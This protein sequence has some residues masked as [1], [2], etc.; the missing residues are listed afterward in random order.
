[1]I[2]LGLTGSIGMGKTTAARQLGSFGIPV[3][4]ADA[5]VHQLLGEGGAAVEPIGR[6][7]PETLVDRSIDRH[8][9]GAR[10][11]G[12]D[13]ALSR[14]EAVLHPLVRRQER[15]FIERSRR[16]RK[17]IVV[18]DVPLL[19]ETGA[20]GRVDAVFVVSCPAFLQAQR[21]LRR[22]GMTL[23]KLTAIRKRQM[24]DWQKR[25]LADSI[26]PTGAGRRLALRTLCAAV[27]HLLKPDRT[28]RRGRAEPIE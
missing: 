18:L 7:F 5:V 4:D 1:M 27:R 28:G 25:R 22:P 9:L 12:D 11:F 3:Y 15:L 8:L 26:I 21:V 2:V 10:V 19:Y 13:R 24:P 17:R 6:I 23:E 14:L 20:S 16:R